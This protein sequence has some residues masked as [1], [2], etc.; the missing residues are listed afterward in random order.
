MGS[1]KFFYILVIDVEAK[2]VNS[3]LA[4]CLGRFFFKPRTVWTNR[5]RTVQN[6]PVRSGLWSGPTN[7]RSDFYG[8]VQIIGEQSGRPG[9]EHT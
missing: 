1:D 2:S 6:G 5:N 8:P 7:W 3:R 9:R 4:D